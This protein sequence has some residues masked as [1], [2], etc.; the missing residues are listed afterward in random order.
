MTKKALVTG[1][2]GYFGS[3][4][5]RN[6]L[7]QGWSVRIFDL[8]EAPDRIKETEFQKGDIRDYA[9][10]AKACDGIDV[11]HHNVAQ[12]PLAKDKKLFESVNRDGTENILK[13]CLENKVTKM[14]YTSSS[15]VFGI[16]ERNPVDDSVKPRPMESYGKAKLEGEL[17]CHKYAEKGL[18]ITI[19]RPRTIMGPGRL[20]IF[21][22]FFDWIFHGEPVYVLGSGNNLYQFVQ[23]DDLADACLKASQKKG[24]SI[25][26]IGAKEFTTM[27]GTIQGLIDY[28]KSKSKIRSLP[29]GI[30]VAAM[31]FTSV[32][33]LSP[34][35]AYHSLMYGREM[36]FDISKAEKDLRYSPKWSN[37]QMFCQ[38]YD[39]FVENRDKIKAQKVGSH[40]RSFLK[41]GALKVLKWLP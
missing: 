24:P 39:W 13:A 30:T 27:R 6:L 40:H 3:V 9:A 11:V 1:G 12:V 38:A 29:F 28:A 35:G 33:G 32:L 7:K 2:S 25:Y 37:V 4:I 21:Y 14:I 10:V 41:E 23:E 19:I 34:L 15:A 22:I 20:G 36:Y 18:D 16:P 8:F 5:V 17:L 31:K 26:N